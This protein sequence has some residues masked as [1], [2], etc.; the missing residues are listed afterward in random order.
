MAFVRSPKFYVIAGIREFISGLI[1]N[2]TE[3]GE[4]SFDSLR[5]EGNIIFSLNYSS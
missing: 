5:R 2:W 3:A 4:D 1:E